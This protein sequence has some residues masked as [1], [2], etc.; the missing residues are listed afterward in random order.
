MAERFDMENY[1][2]DLS[3]GLQEK[4]RACKTKE[5]LLQLAADEDIEIPMD[6]LEGVAGGC[7][8]THSEFT[9]GSDVGDKCPDCG[10]ALIYCD[11]V[12]EGIYECM[13]VYCKK[14]GKKFKRV[15]RFGTRDY[16]PWTD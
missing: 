12:F 3:P 8:V 4:A 16:E 5:E 14:C 7:D 2:K 13:H 6:A 10:G 11:M 1:M 15:N 9:A